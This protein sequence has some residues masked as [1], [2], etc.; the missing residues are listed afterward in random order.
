MLIIVKVYTGNVVA[1]QCTQDTKY[2][3]IKYTV[4]SRKYTPPPSF[5]TLALVQN[6]GG[7]GGGLYVECD[8]FSRDYALPSDK[9]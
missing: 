1:E 8:N 7:W 9:A 3:E 6:A 5:A 4:V 2:V